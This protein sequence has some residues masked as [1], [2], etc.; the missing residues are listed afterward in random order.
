MLW[1]LLNTGLAVRC[2]H[3]TLLP[4]GLSVLFLL[5]LLFCSISPIAPTR[6]LMMCVRFSGV[7]LCPFSIWFLER[8]DTRVRKPAAFRCLLQPERS[9]PAP[10]GVSLAE[11][12]SVNNEA[13]KICCT[14]INIAYTRRVLWRL[15]HSLFNTRF[16]GSS[17]PARR[18]PSGVVGV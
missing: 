16:V 2:G 12:Q 15:F 13:P 18:R 17:L 5:L 1:K 11:N 7:P 3:K 6:L 8:V 14:I 9:T 10:K 4:S